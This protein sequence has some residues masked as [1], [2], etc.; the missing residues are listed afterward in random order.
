[1]AQELDMDGAPRGA[2][3]VQLLRR[4]RLV[5]EGQRD[6]GLVFDQ[7]DT[8][9]AA[10]Q[11]IAGVIGADQ[12]QRP[13]AHGESLGH[14]VQPADGESDLAEHADGSGVQ[15]VDGPGAER[16]GLAVMG[17]LQTAGH[18]LEH[19]AGPRAQLFLLDNAVAVLVEHEDR[20]QIGQ[21][22]L[23]PAGQLGVGDVEIDIALASPVGGG[24]AG[25]A[26]EEQRQQQGGPTPEADG[27]GG[28]GGGG[29][30]R[31]VLR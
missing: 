11:H 29:H 30:L 24:G 13:I 2:H 31:A 20:V 8:A 22:H 5:R 26:E 21:L 15:H 14:G 9:V 19:R 6:I 27:S 4:V 1:M 12:G 28:R 23:E 10:N 3:Q 7:P 18:E 25:Q 16:Q 17:Q